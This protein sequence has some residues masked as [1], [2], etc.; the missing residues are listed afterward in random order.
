MQLNIREKK[1]LRKIYILLAIAF[2]ASILFLGSLF[3][4]SNHSSFYIWFWKYS[5]D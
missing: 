5:Y 2:A 4:F 1:E 3:V